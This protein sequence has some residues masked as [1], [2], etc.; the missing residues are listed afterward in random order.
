MTED[1]IRR[2][3]ARL[4]DLIVPFVRLFG[5][6]EAQLHA[7]TY[8][9]G[10]MSSLARKSIEPIALAV[11]GGRTSALQKF[12]NVAPWRASSVHKEVQRDFGEWSRKRAEGPVV[13]TIHEHAFIKKG[14]ESVG[15][16]RQWTEATRRTE[17]CQIGIFL[18]ATAGE[19]SCLLDSR[20]YLPAS[21][22]D[23]SDVARRRRLRTHVP[24]G[25]PHRTKPQIALDLLRRCLSMGLVD[26]GWVVIGEG[27]SGGGELLEGLDPRNQHYMIGIPPK[28]V[29][30]AR[31]PA[32]PGASA[33][34]PA[35]A[36]HGNDEV[37]TTVSSLCEALPAESWRTSVTRGPGGVT[38]EEF[39]VVRV[40]SPLPSMASR[41]LSL[42]IRGGPDLEC[43]SIKYYFA[44]IGPETSPDVIAAALRAAESAPGFFHEAERHLGLSHYET[45]SWDGWH[46][47]M[48]LVA[49]AHWLA[50]SGAQPPHEPSAVSSP[51]LTSNGVD[52]V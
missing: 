21:W 10:L 51:G 34:G 30:F 39:A 27:F 37:A 40:R 16:A 36:P 38:H 25:T 48:S 42:I 45:R 18:V 49:L 8:L 43:S 15:V 11:G 19:V 50:G 32:H 44:D 41:P 4:E 13:L 28:E 5:K 31:S 33:S 20:L 47:H 14:R 3:A 6:E 35:L 46:H 22:C 7:R 2:A 29:V 52:P 17:N 24:N 26:P 12:I 9:K 1:D 23:G